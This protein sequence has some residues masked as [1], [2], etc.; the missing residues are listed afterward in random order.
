ME[1]KT[2]DIDPRA[3][4]RRNRWLAN[5]SCLPAANSLKQ[6]IDGHGCQFQKRE[7]MNIKKKNKPQKP[8]TTTKTD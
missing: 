3:S 6:L 8:N 1:R 4:F 2:Q 5:M 7:K